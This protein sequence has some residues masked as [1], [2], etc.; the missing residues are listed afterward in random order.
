MPGPLTIRSSQPE[1]ARQWLRSGAPIAQRLAGRCPTRRPM[2]SGSAF[3]A[4]IILLGASSLATSG[5]NWLASRITSSI[6]T[7]GAFRPVC[8]LEDL[9]VAPEARGHG[10]GRFLIEG[11]VALGRERSWRRIYCHTHGNN[12]A[13]RALYDQLAPSTDYVRYDIDLSP[14]PRNA[15]GR[16]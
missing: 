14:C 10:A 16:W 12:H 3:S 7:P 8:Y 1:D 11:L 4:P 15:N 2:A 5:W 6:R 13:A 9:Y